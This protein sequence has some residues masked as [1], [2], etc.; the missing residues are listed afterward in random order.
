M[1]VLS[2]VAV[3]IFIS[4]LTGCQVGNRLFSVSVS[5]YSDCRCQPAAAP[6][7]PSGP[8][9]GN[10]PAD[11][12]IR[13]ALS[14]PSDVLSTE[15]PEMDAATAVRP[16]LENDQSHRRNREK[17]ILVPEVSQVFPSPT[18]DVRA[19]H[20]RVAAQMLPAVEPEAFE[21]IEP[22]VFVD[23]PTPAPEK[24]QRAAELPHVNTAVAPLPPV[25]M[26]V[27]SADETESITPVEPELNDRETQPIT[28]ESLDQLLTQ[29]QQVA[30]PELSFDPDDLTTAQAATEDRQPQS[31]T[32]ATV[33]QTPP[34]TRSEPGSITDDQQVE[35]TP[36][37]EPIVLHARPVQSHTVSNAK[38]GQPAAAAID[39]LAVEQTLESNGVDSEFGLP[40]GND[41]EFAE[42]PEMDSDVHQDAQQV[43]Y[44]D[45]FGRPVL[46]PPTH[47]ATGSSPAASGQPGADSITG[48]PTQY[49]LPPQQLVRLRAET[50]LGKVVPRPSKATILMRDT[51]I[52]RGR[53]LLDDDGSLTPQQNTSRIAENSSDISPTLRQAL[54]RLT[55]DS[56]SPEVKR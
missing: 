2:F 28:S 11:G 13:D 50:P 41:I 21:T 47:P 12:L 32:Q 52:V 35:L 27:I 10:A 18:D 20:E 7:Q 44:R 48:Q 56:V 1:R 23:N 46:A 54:R 22:N 43:V 29:P 45:E 55:N 4:T 30:E 39:V 15:L 9:L 16:Q 26:Q 19:R 6:I 42:L 51:V 14:P 34:E 3:A 24:A 49:Y 36:Q 8:S 17:S 25:E 53:R 40:T 5:S 38:L 37:H 33:E 31:T